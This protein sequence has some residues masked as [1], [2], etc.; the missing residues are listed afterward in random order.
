VRAGLTAPERLRGENR[1]EAVGDDNETS[2]GGTPFIEV[3]Y[4]AA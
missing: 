4:D 2:A 1:A 3:G